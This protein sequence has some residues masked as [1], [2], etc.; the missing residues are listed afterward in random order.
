VVVHRGNPVLYLSLSGVA[1]AQ[2]SLVFAEKSNA[3]GCDPCGVFLDAYRHRHFTPQKSHNMPPQIKQ[4][5]NRSG[6]ETTDFPSVCEKYVFL[7]ICAL[8]AFDD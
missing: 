2:I 1:Q 5:L 8:L 4:D 6:W 7:L 3:Q